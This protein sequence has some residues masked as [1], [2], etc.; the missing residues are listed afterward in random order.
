MK[1]CSLS[2]VIMEMQMKTTWDTTTHPF[3]WL[4]C[5]RLMT[6]NVDEDVKKKKNSLTLLMGE[7]NG[8]TSLETGMEI[9]YDVKH[10]SFGIYLRE[11]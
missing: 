6:S 8:T 5:K 11:M 9:T 3:K 10:L 2:L 1:Q 7:K 4:K